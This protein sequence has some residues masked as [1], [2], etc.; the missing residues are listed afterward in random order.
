[1]E[2]LASTIDKTVQLVPPAEEEAATTALGATVL[3][4]VICLSANFGG[5]LIEDFQ[6]TTMLLE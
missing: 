5:L 4:A 2:S 6:Q 3:R 1:V